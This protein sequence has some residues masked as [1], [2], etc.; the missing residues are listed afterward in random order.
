MSTLEAIGEARQRLAERLTKLD[1][2]R[3]KLAAD[4]AELE[5]AERVVARFATAKAPPASRPRRSAAKGPGV[6]LGDATLRAVVAHDHGA[7][8]QDVRK[9]LAERLGMEV[10]ANHLGMALQRHRRAGRLEQRELLWYPRQWPGNGAA[11]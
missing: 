6:S 3:A 1:A 8:A 7:S 11:D 4:L 2:E 9:F 5:A 10:R